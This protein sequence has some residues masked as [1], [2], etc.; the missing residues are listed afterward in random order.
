MELHWS[1][2]HSLS[3][4]VTD[5]CG[6]LTS[7]FRE[8]SLEI[9]HCLLNWI[10]RR[11]SSWIRSSIRGHRSSSGRDLGVDSSNSVEIAL[12]SSLSRVNCHLIWEVKVGWEPSFQAGL[13]VGSVSP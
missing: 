12:H 7:A 6:Q 8:G 11:V 10:F 1:F 3:W 9:C 13:E 4:L 2:L 5:L